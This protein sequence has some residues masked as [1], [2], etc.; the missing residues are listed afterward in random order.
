[1]TRKKQ[2]KVQQPVEQPGAADD[3]KTAPAASA[4]GDEEG[5]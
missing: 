1:M 4:A 5:D 2:R 3:E